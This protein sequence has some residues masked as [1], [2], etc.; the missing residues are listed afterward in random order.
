MRKISDEFMVLSMLDAQQLLAY[1]TNTIKGV[2]PGVAA[3]QTF[4]SLCGFIDGDSGKVQRTASEA[5]TSADASV[6]LNYLIALSKEQDAVKESGMTHELLEATKHLAC[7]TM[8]FRNRAAAIKITRQKT[9]MSLSDAAAWVNFHYASVLDLGRSGVGESAP[10][11]KPQEN[12]AFG[13]SYREEIVDRTVQDLGLVCFPQFHRAQTS[14]QMT[15]VEPN[16]NGLVQAVPNSTGFVVEYVTSRVLDEKLFEAHSPV[17]ARMKDGQLLGTVGH[18]RMLAGEH[19]L[20]YLER[21]LVVDVNEVCLRVVGIERIDQHRLRIHIRPAGPKAEI[22]EKLLQEEQPFRL[23]AR[24]VIYPLDNSIR[25]IVSF[26]L[27]PPT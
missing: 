25:N 14:E 26:D 7:P 10:N 13:T 3:R 1:I 2:E 24:Y 9:G 20:D 4:R 27:L 8:D 21:A 23:G 12:K 6:R 19:S 5:A 15:L 17:L 22:T 16:Q 11:T 18:P